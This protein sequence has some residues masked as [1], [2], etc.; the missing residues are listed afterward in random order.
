MLKPAVTLKSRR[1]KGL[2]GAAAFLLLAAR[3]ATAQTPA[4]LAFRAVH[5]D[6]DVTLHPA[7]QTLSAKARVEFVGASASRA[8]LV[9]L[10]QDL[11]VASV[12]GT[13]GKSFEFERDS[14]SPLDLKVSLPDVV[15]PGKHLTLVFDYAGSVSNE[16]DSP[17]KGLRLAAVD[18]SS[19]YLLLPAR[20]FPL[21]DYPSNRYTAVFKITVPDTFA[22]A[23]TGKAAAP[24]AVPASG[25][26]PSQIA[27]TFKSDTAAPVGTFV[28]GAIRLTP[29]QSQ[30]LNISVFAP[31]SA[32]AA[33]GYGNA[34]ASIV[35]FFS[36]EFAPL[37][38]PNLTIAQMP[39]GSVA[40]FSAP[41]LLLVS[42]RQ[43]TAKVNESLLAQLAAGQWWGSQVLAASPSDVWLTDGLAR[44]SEALYIQ[45]AENAPGL[46]RMLEEF[47]VSALMYD[48]A[49][50]IA[51]A[52]RL[53]LYSVEYRSVVVNKGAMVFQMLHALLGDSIFQSL[54]HDFYLKFA[55]KTVRLEDFE[56]MAEARAPA[57]SAGK[58]PLNL[59][60]FFSQW[61]N[62][63]G[64]P[65]FKTDY[66]VY[67]TKKGFKVVGKIQQDLET[68]NMPVELRV[69]TE[70]N[71]ETK[72]IQATGLNTEFQIDTFGRPKPN[73]LTVDPNNNLLKSSP[74]LRV[75]AAVAR[76]EALA[77]QGKYFEAIQEYQKAVD[78]QGNN[79]LG[80]FR[81]AEAM[82]Y[83]KN[84]QAAANEFRSA[85]DGDLDPKWTEVWSHVYLGKIFD[86]T[87]QRERAV[88]E[89]SRAEQLKDDT[90][91]AQ[92]EAARY[93]QK[94]YTGDA[95]PSSAA[96]AKP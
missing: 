64:V 73:G 80:H 31:A 39:D 19:A 95:T 8:L 71:P 84:Y 72:T 78:V 23:G 32:P 65:E 81:M 86:L 17:S 29:V 56:K 4:P 93:L 75:H 87:G 55:G 10:H 59:V 38:D 21:T 60:A 51:Q 7:D 45:Q 85:L 53:Q 6:V 82:F 26:T 20:W 9:E 14:S 47:A 40:G 69:D 33:Q 3:A 57:R 58:P 52:Q 13:D 25:K 27:Y 11:K 30:G 62:S 77:E 83:Q 67:R 43:W 76:G 88:N 18:R 34:L 63:T 1:V 70:G 16:D 37:A 35:N 90:S 94:P 36:S 12:R 68:F 89:Y 66:I 28:A 74:R 41:G 50:P 2:L 42:A 49:A 48:D 46:H 54:L 92:E 24:S 91:G 96:T 61:L 79:S 15:E 22:V 5:Y 44:Y